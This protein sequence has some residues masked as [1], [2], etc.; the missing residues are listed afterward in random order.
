MNVNDQSNKFYKNN[1]NDS[2]WWLDNADDIKGEWEFTFDKKKF[3]NLFAD[4]P[5]NLTQKKKR[6][7]IKRT[8]IGKTF[9]RQTITISTQ[10]IMCFLIPLIKALD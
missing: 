6:Y 8:H 3:F 2:I 9:Q 4:Y 1:K 7:S 5:H 10:N